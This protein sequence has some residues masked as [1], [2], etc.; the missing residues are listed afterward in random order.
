MLSIS[1]LPFLGPDLCLHRLV[2]RL[3]Y[4]FGDLRPFLA[5]LIA[6]NL[7]FLVV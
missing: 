6:P 5:V 2:L 4:D 1:N 7:P 3:D